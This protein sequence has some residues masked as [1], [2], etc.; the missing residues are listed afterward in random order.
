MLFPGFPSGFNNVLTRYVDPY[1]LTNI[2]KAHFKRAVQFKANHFILSSKAKLQE[3]K[4]HMVQ[5]AR[6][7]FSVTSL[8]TL[9]AHPYS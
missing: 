7:G 3:Y 8:K 9:Q 5:T 2:Q 6:Y 1:F 4:T